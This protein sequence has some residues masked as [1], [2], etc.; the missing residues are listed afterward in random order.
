MIT[1]SAAL[2]GL[3]G[4]VTPATPQLSA[5]RTV[6]AARTSL[7]WDAPELSV[8]SEIRGAR[9]GPRLRCTLGHDGWTALATSRTVGVRRSWNAVSN[10]DATGVM[11]FKDKPRQAEDA[12]KS[13]QS[14]RLC[15]RLGLDGVELGLCDRATVK[16]LLGLLDLGRRP[17]TAA[18]GLAHV[19]VELRLGSLRF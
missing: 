11:A 17:A 15:E 7:T 8:T 5:P 14:S 16:E 1:R 9:P 4:P 12:C 10:V 18:S 6:A 19:L 3:I 13:R 2:R